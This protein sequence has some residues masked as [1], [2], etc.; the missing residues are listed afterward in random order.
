MT[1]ATVLHVRSISGRL[2]SISVSQRLKTNNQPSTSAKRVDRWKIET[3]SQKVAADKELAFETS[4]NTLSK[5]FSSS[6]FSN[7][8]IAEVRIVL[9]SR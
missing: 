3:Q 8:K 2:Y 1:T 5:T 4:I 9:E 7:T 6:I